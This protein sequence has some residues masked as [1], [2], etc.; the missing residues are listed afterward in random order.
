[1]EERRRV[2]LRA[3]D[4]EEAGKRRETVVS[5][6]V[7]TPVIVRVSLKAPAIQAAAPATARAKRAAD[8][9]AEAGVQLDTGKVRNH[10]RTNMSA[11]RNTRR[12]VDD[13]NWEGWEG[14]FTTLFHSTMTTCAAIEGRHDDIN[15][16]PLIVLYN[17]WTMHMWIVAL[18]LSQPMPADITWSDNTG[19][20]CWS[21]LCTHP[22][23][24]WRKLES[25]GKEKEKEIVS[26]QGI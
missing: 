17:W 24:C 6:R 9:V 16:L 15:T 10:R 22:H 5:D 21:W 20:A 3:R 23:S 1:M 18:W 7:S 26:F 25:Q 11:P 14:V 4:R 2:P 13:W 19:H 12:W 8:L